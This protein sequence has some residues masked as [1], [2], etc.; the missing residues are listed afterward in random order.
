MCFSIKEVAWLLGKRSG[1]EAIYFILILLY[2]QNVC[3]IIS[4]CN[5]DYLY[6]NRLRI[7]LNP[8]TERC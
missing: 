6:T 2:S 8:D 4:V 5:R 7:F 1:K 3:L